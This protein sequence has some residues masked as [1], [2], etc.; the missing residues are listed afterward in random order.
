MV[1]TLKTGFL[2]FP[3][4]LPLILGLTELPKHAE[5]HPN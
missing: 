3:V 4:D 5:S 1:F 2:M